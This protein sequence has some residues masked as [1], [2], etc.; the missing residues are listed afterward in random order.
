MRTM[1]SPLCVGVATAAVLGFAP[2]ATPAGSTETIQLISITTYSHQEP[3][4]AK[5]GDY[6]V[7]SRDDLMNAAPQFGRRSGVRVGT[8][9]GRFTYTPAHIA[10]DTGVTR[11]PGGTVNVR[12]MAFAHDGKVLIRVVGGSGKYKGATGFLTIGVG[13]AK[14]KTRST[15]TYELTLPLP[16]GNTS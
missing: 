14:S 2:V 15:N 16:T 13:P 7:D 5:S 3:T 1:R 10:T 9:V 12:G 11:L 6:S 4:D 8:D